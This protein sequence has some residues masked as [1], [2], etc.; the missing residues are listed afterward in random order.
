MIYDERKI[1]LMDIAL[2]EAKKAYKKGEVPVGALIIKDDKIISKAHNT[3]QKNSNVLN[4]AEI[5]AINKAIKKLNS[6]YLFDCELYV[7]LEPCPMCAGAIL[8]SKI[9]KVYIATK[10]PKSGY[11]GTIHDTLNDKYLNHKTE[12]HFGIREEESSQLLKTFF[13]ELRNS[14]KTK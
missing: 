9:N 10:D 6:K 11:A 13:K 1:K 7:T 2:S 4:H 8:L 3:I 5:V 14:K 12:V